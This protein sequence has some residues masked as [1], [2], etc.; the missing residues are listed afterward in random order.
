MPA[1]ALQPVGE[2]HAEEWE[3][4]M[5]AAIDAAVGDAPDTTALRVLLPGSSPAAA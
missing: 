1:D 5:D 4:G 2:F 3:K